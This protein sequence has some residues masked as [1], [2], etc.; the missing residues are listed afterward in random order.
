MNIFDGGLKAATYRS[1]ELSSKG[2]RLEQERNARILIVQCRKTVNAYQLALQ[3]V[4]SAREAYKE[5]AA[6][7]SSA[8]QEYAL[9]A[10]SMVDLVGLEEQ[11]ASSMQQLIETM[12]TLTK[13]SYELKRLAGQLT[14][15]ML[16]VRGKKYSIDAYR[17]D[18]RLNLFGLGE[19]QSKTSLYDVA[20]PSDARV[21]SE[22][23]QLF[24]RTMDQKNMKSGM[25]DEFMQF[26]GWYPVGGVAPIVGQEKTQ[27]EKDSK[28]IKEIV[29]GLESSGEE[30]KIIE[31]LM[32]E[33][34]GNNVLDDIMINEVAKEPESGVNKAAVKKASA[35]TDS[36]KKAAAKKAPAKKPSAKK[37][38][39]QKAP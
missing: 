34:L 17:D 10:T 36:V 12:S 13:I 18:Y 3:N 19:N 20:E 11:Y 22:L 26:F 9:G 28:K 33:S 6:A 25:N 8:R 7:F 16:Q 24:D 23:L 1:A 38:P 35:K 31:K 4:V 30:N 39:V 2:M 27:I 15:D 29:Q 37:A 14:P 32:A 5:Q 21:G